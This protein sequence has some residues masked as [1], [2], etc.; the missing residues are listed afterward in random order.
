MARLLIAG[1]GFLGEAL[2]KVFS[3]A[4]WEVDKLSRSGRDTCIRCDIS[5]PE[6]VASLV[7]E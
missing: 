6:D 3:E 4:G 2:D 5:S 1:Y 7:G